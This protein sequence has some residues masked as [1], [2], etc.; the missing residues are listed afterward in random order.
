MPINILSINAKGLNHP[1][2][3]KS[4]WREALLHHS[5]IICAQEPHFNNQAPP[6][7]SHKSFPHVFTTNADSKTKGV[8]TAI[9]DSVAFTLHEQIQDPLGRFLILICELNSITYTLVNIYSPN[10]HQVHFFNK[11]MKKVKSHK[12]GLLVICGDFNVTPD[13][14]MDSTSKTTRH[15]PTLLPSLHKQNIYDA[16]RCLHAGKKDFTFFSPPHRVY[17]SIDLFLVDQQV[18]LRT[19]SVAINSITWSDHMSIFLCIADSASSG[20]SPIWRLNTF[21]LQQRELKEK[22]RT[23]LTDL[24]AENEGSV[25]SPFAHKAFLRGIFIQMGGRIKRQRQQR[26]NKLTKK[27]SDLETQNK[28]K[29]SPTLSLKLTALRSD[30][31][32]HLLENVEKTTKRLRMNYYAT[33]NKAGKLLAQTLKGHRYKSKVP[34]IIHPKTKQK[35]YHPQEIADAFTYYYGT[36]YNLKDDP[37]TIQP[38]PRP[39]INS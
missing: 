17:T 4:L 14:T 37:S 25:L 33:G 3:R 22:I 15:H 16:W 20:L 30:L 27:I 23:H 35:E 26:L 38:T 1:V 10:K 39:L 12:K 8:L 31:R 11:R 18:L 28:H 21:L 2:K 13:P 5:D 7:C 29:P 19:E 34:Y 32:L 24:F 9:C 6:K 36:L